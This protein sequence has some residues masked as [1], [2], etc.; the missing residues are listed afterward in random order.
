[1]KVKPRPIGCLAQMKEEHSGFR[2]TGLLLWEKSSNVRVEDLQNPW[3]QGLCGQ[4]PWDVP[5]T[6]DTP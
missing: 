5:N 4:V 2:G 3:G 1:M 6:C